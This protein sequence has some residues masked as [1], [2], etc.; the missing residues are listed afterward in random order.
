MADVVAKVT[1]NPIR[2]GDA[3]ALD[4]ANAI[5]ANNRGQVQADTWITAMTARL[6]GRFR[7]RLYYTTGSADPADP[8]P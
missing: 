8:T 2:E 7:H 5:V 3:V 4:E 6:G 1:A